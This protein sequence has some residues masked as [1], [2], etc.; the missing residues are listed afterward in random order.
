[1]KLC[2]Q[3]LEAAVNSS[4]SGGRYSKNSRKRGNNRSHNGA[5]SQ[6]SNTLSTYCLFSI[7]LEVFYFVTRLVRWMHREGFSHSTGPSPLALAVSCSG[8]G[9]LV[10]QLNLVPFFLLFLIIFLHTSQEAVSA[11]RMLNVLSIYINSLGKNPAF[12]LFTIPA[13]CG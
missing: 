3:L 8:W 13:A 5:L 11:I 9:R 4:T 2:K 6:M 1:M 7:Q 12:N 10:P